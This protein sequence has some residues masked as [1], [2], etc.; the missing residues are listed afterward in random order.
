MPTYVT[1]PRFAT[2]L[3]HLT[4]AQRQHFRRVV[5]EAFTPDLRTEL[6]RPAPGIKRVRCTPGVFDR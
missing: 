1:L 4:R 5:R 6:I 3:Q 2:G